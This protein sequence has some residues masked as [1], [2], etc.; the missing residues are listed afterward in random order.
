MGIGG[1]G[2]REIEIQ[3]AKKAVG[4]RDR[5][6]KSLLPVL[7]LLETDLRETGGKPFGRGW[8]SLGEVSLK[9]KSK[10][11]HCHLNPRNVAVWLLVKGL[12]TVCKFI[13][14]GSREKAPY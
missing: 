14:V 3:Y 8:M 12:K 1:T 6:S 13:Y 7:E 9:D 10:A 2:K 4:M 11:M 5:L